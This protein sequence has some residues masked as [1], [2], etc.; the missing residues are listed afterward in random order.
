MV[1][2]SDGQTQNDDKEKMALFA[3]KLKKVRLILNRIKLHFNAELE[4]PTYFPD[5]V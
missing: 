4:P 5:D 2:I 1:L 3:A